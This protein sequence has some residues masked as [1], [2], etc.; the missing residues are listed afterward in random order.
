MARE[1]EVGPGD[2][3]PTMLPTRPGFP[4]TWKTWKLMEFLVW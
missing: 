3:G 2:V 1:D 4:L